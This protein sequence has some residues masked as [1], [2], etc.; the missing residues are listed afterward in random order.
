[1]SVIGRWEGMIVM[2]QFNKHLEPPKIIDI[3]FYW[4]FICSIYSKYSGAFSNGHFSTHVILDSL[5][6]SVSHSPNL[7]LSSS[8]SLSSAHYPLR[9]YLPPV[10][11]KNTDFVRSASLNKLIWT[12]I[13]PQLGL[14]HNKRR[15]LGHQSVTVKLGDLEKLPRVKNSWVLKWKNVGKM[16]VIYF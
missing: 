4:R 7:L 6:D 9:I 16:K 3:C 15:D 2:A 1:M 8:I 5:L 10:D 14:A 13:V 11:I 12:N